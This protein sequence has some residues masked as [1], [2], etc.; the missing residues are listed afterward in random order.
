MNL[1]PTNVLLVDDNEAF[2][3]STVW[4]LE[5]ADMLVNDF[6]S[7]KDLLN[8]LKSADNNPPCCIVTDMRMPEM[9][10]LELMEELRKRHD[11]HAVVLITAHGDIPLAVEAMR[12]GAVSVLEKPFN[13]EMLIQTIRNAL[14]EPGAQ[15]RNPQAAK[16]RLERLS[17]REKQVLDL[18]SAGQLNKCIA[19]KLGI[20]IK[21]VEL[22]RAN[23]VTKLGVR[24]VQELVRLTLGY[25]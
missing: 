7:G 15:L 25:A 17:P 18:V 24:N 14:A 1:Q 23:M 22:H 2:R 8:F 19:D 9:N 11:K 12:R 20:S 10:G 16:I 4:L 5:G 6:Q 3:R 13:D 21:T